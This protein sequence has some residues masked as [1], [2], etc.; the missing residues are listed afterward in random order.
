MRAFILGVAIGIGL[1]AL[2]RS[3]ELANFFGGAK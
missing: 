2:W 1:V 3:S